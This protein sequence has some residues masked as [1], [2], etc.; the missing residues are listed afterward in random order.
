MNEIMQ[1]LPLLFLCLIILFICNYWLKK[2]IKHKNEFSDFDEKLNFHYYS[3]LKIKYGKYFSIFILTV[4][5]L[6][7]FYILLSKWLGI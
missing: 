1:L 5:I 7:I 4:I 3:N 6:K 2:N